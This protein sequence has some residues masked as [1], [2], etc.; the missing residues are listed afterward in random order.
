MAPSR[1]EIDPITGY[2]NNI[3]SI[4]ASEY[5][6]LTDLTY[7]D[8]SGTT[9]YAKSLIEA[10]SKDLTTNL[11]GNPHSASGSSQLSTQRVDDA[12]LEVLRFLKADPDVFDVVFTANATTAIKIVADAFREQPGGFQY[13]YHVDSHTSLIGV[14]E[15]S[16]RAECLTSHDA[17]ESWLKQGSSEVVQQPQLLAYPG[18]SN[19]TGRRYG[20][21]WAEMSNELRSTGQQCYTLFDAAALASTAPI[22]LSNPQIAPSFTALSF[23]K[24]FGFPDLGA[25]IVKKDAGRI[26]TQRRYFG[27]GTVEAVAVSGKTWHEVRDTSIHA[28]L[29]DGTL[30]FHNIIALQHALRLHRT[31]YKSMT[32]I[33]RHCEH[34]ANMLRKQLTEMRHG[35][36]RP[37]C[38]MYGMER[39]AGEDAGP[40]VSFNLLDR[41]GEYVSNAEVEK[42]AIVKKIH[43]RTGGLC[44][45]GG[46]VT[47][48]GLTPNDLRR[49]YQ[50]GYRCGGLGDIINGKPPGQSDLKDV[51]TFIAFIREYYCDTSPHSPPC[52]PTPKPK[53]HTFTIESLT[54][55]PIK[56]CAAFPIPSYANWQVG[57]RGLL[58]DR[59]WCL[60]H[61]GTHQA[62]S[63]KKYPKMAL[64]RPTI[65]LHQQ[66]LTITHNLNGQSRPQALTIALGDNSNLLSIDSTICTRKP[67]SVC[68]EP[69]SIEHYTA[70]HITEFFSSA[71]NVPCTLARFPHSGVLRKPQIRGLPDVNTDR[72]I[73]LAN[74]SPILLVSRS[75]VNRLNEDIKARIASSTIKPGKA[76]PAEAFRG[77]IVIAETLVRGQKEHPYAEDDWTTISIF[78]DASSTGENGDKTQFDVLGPC[79]RCQMV[80]IDQTDATRRQEPFSTLAKTRR[81]EG[82][83]WFGAHLALVGG[84][85]G[86]E[87]DGGGEKGWVKVGDRVECY[88]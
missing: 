12:R 52:N 16:P 30:P 11:F 69:V 62:L 29:E 87:L 4:R 27:G 78:N 21:R 73:A 83:V 75:S 10:F 58:H 28:Q 50:A 76:V 63:Q 55:F 86:D 80:C 26:L 56:S 19:M 72:A 71:L 5:P 77:N 42:L 68:G 64:L 67:T 45:P 38:Q 37:V 8:H 15:L 88:S 60:V 70:P 66:T 22:D 7:L 84:R 39:E 32:D 36:G 65:D 81:R 1:V 34:L 82:K 13:G 17:V 48:L 47:A 57:A 20:F 33:S 54:I 46:T 74:E 53:K 9:L 59:E 79:Q 18:Q 25:L 40:V 24:I 49:N 41:H 23:Y 61:L 3:D 51:E 31:L 35:V 2:F 43:L 6:Q 44:N 85:G 14:R